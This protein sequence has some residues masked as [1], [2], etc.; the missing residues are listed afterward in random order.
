MRRWEARF[1]LNRKIQRDQVKSPLL[2]Q[3]ESDVGVAAFG[4]RFAAAAGD[5]DVLPAV[6]HV[7]GGGGVAAG[8]KFR[9]PENP[10]GFLVIRMHHLVVGRGNENQAAGGEH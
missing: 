8:G 9:L 7:G 1:I 4:A 10:A 3:G 6:K 5:D 2:W